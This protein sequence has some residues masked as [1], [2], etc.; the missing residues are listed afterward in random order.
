MTVNINNSSH[1]EVASESVS[2]KFRK[3][4]GPGVSYIKFNVGRNC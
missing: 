3:V 4:Y 2:E 1:L